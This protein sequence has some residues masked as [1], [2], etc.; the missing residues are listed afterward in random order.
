MQ[1]EKVIEIVKNALEDMKAKDIIDLDVRGRS[2]VTDHMII[3]SGTSKRHVGAVAEEVIIKVKEAGLLPLGSEGQGVS[4]W[5]LVD[6][7]DVVVHV[8]MPDA[9]EFY[10]LERLWG[11]EKDA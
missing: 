2:T 8:M 5:I 1:T 3:A 9:R 7:G 10:D 4:D 11:V 6:L